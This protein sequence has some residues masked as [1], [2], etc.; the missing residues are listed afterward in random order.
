M[1][2]VIVTRDTD[3]CSAFNAR[4]TEREQ[5][6]RYRDRYRIGRRARIDAR[7][8]EVLRDLLGAVG[9]VSVALDIPGGTGRLTSLI[10]EFSDRVIL[11][12]RS[13]AMLEVAREDL[14]DPH[15]E[16]LKTD[17][18]SIELETASV[19]LVFSH[20]FLHHIH[21]AEAR[22]CVFRE[23]A[24]VSRRY[25]IA[26]YYTPGFRDWSRYLSSR[27]IRSA[28]RLD[29]PATMARFFEETAVV[30]LRSREV[31]F[32]RRFPLTALF[33]LFDRS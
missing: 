17:A 11:G 28:R 25:V 21:S 20:R 31:R 15:V 22:A 1:D 26:S 8:R 13:P 14:S 2:K 12:D 27:A 32:L 18:Q 5:A 10:A 24:R 16:Y 4:F 33:C 3:D 9:H 7:E 30:G 6:E 23:F 19:D 29:R